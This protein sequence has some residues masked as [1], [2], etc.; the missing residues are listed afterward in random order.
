MESEYSEYKNS[1]YLN[2]LS[3]SVSKYGYVSES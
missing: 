3:S 1:Y 2:G